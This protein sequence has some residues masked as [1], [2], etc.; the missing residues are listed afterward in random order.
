MFLALFFIYIYQKGLESKKIRELEL[1]CK[2]Q[3]VLENKDRKVKDSNRKY[4]SSRHIQKHFINHLFL[5]FYLPVFSLS[6][7][8][9]ISII[10][11]FAPLFSG[12]LYHMFASI[13]LKQSSVDWKYLF[14]LSVVLSA[15]KTVATNY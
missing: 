14:H 5:G 15:T 8:M 10:H 1:D 4:H 6:F 9:C 11:N 2:Y 3:S 12:L 7:Q 13:V